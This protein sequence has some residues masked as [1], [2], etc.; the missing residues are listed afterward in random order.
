MTDRIA[1]ESTLT[2]GVAGLMVAFVAGSGLARDAGDTD[3]TAPR[4]GAPQDV[5]DPDLDSIR[6]LLPRELSGFTRA[7]ITEEVDQGHAVLRAVYRGVGRALPEFRVWVL[8]G[9]AAQRTVHERMVSATRREGGISERTVDG[10]PVYERLAADDIVWAAF[11][12]AFVVGFEADGGLE[13]AGAEERIRE[14]LEA[15]L[16][17]L[18]RDVLSPFSSTGGSGPGEGAPG[19]GS[20]GFVRSTVVWD[21]LSFSLRR[22][23][24]WAVTDL[25]SPSGIPMAL[26]LVRDRT[27]SPDQ[28]GS[29]GDLSAGEAVSL[30]SEEN[31]VVRLSAASGRP[32]RTAPARFLQELAGSGRLEEMLRQGATTG[33][34]H[35]RAAGGDSLAAVPF[36]GRDREGREVHGWI[37]GIP[38]GDGMLQ[39]RVMVGPAAPAAAVDTAERVLGSVGPVGGG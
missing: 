24:D 21:H 10:V 32:G 35:M 39:G 34:V 13:G 1:F 22:P 31:V 20:G 7:E 26:L 38:V 25:N 3:G 27:V 17:Q 6:D 9:R 37:Y 12:G 28:L 8:H 36:R 14:V 23:G 16:E 30:G 2:A 4:R 15:A 33:E 18:R 5:S 11:P 19:P 29:A